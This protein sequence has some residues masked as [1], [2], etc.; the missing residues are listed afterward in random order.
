MCAMSRKISIGWFK[1]RSGAYALKGITV[2]EGDRAFD[3]TNS[4]RDEDAKW[5][6]GMLGA[7]ADVE[8]STNNVGF[9]TPDDY[10]AWA[11]KTGV[12][13]DSNGVP[14]L[15]WERARAALLRH[16]LTRMVEACDA[17]NGSSD[18]AQSIATLQKLVREADAVLLATDAGPYYT[19]EEARIIVERHN[20]KP[21]KKR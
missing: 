21:A 1:Q 16:V 7:Q 8:L 17:G 18:D 19:L 20:Q 13:P 4:F 15:D 10:P 11:L 6:T 14:A 12:E 9:R 5:L 3:S 2:R